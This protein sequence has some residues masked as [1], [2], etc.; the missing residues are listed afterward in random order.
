MKLMFGK[1]AA[2]AVAVA[3][4]AAIAVPAHSAVELKV[5]TALG[6]KHDQS[7]AF[8][9]LFVGKMKEDES[10]VKL[11]YLGGPEVTPNR[12]QGPAMKRGLID[13]IMSPCTYYANVVSEAR[14]HGIAPVPSSTWRKNGAYDIMS[15]AWAKKL[16]AVIL[17]WGNFYGFNQF[18]M[19]MKEKPKFSKVTGLDLKGVKMRTTPLYTPFL[20]AM[21][22]TT[23]NISP[24]EVYTALE[25]GVVDGL[26]WPEGGVA[27]RGWQRYIKYRVEPG[28]FRSTTMATM[29]KT[30]F[31]KLPKAARDQI[32]AAGLHYENNSG[33]LLKKLA[34]VD[35]AKIY[36]AGVKRLVLP[37]EIAKVYVDTIVSANWKAAEK[38]KYLEDFAKMK[39]VMTVSK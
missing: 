33:A 6:T 27:F 28:F 2:T 7:K 1:L 38:Y 36:K 9:K 10:L 14:L 8:L 23:K 35:N 25:R 21:G 3:T 26:A 24:A 13:I 34:A 11:N 31:D 32:V 19:W 22:A 15:R 30:K 5:T 16:N 37:P 17:G 20:K 29:N 39:A 12:K 4:A 18:F